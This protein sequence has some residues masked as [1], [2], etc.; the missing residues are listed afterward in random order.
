MRRRAG[1]AASLTHLEEV[2]YEYLAV[3]MGKGSSTHGREQD[4]SA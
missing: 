1:L 3:V 4:L 2:D